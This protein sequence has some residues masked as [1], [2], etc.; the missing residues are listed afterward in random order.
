MPRYHVRVVP[1]NGKPDL[2]L[3]RKYTDFHDGPFTPEF[4]SRV[5]FVKPNGAERRIAAERDRQPN[6]Y[7]GDVTFVVVEEADESVCIHC[8]KPIRNVAY[9]NGLAR[10]EDDQG[11]DICGWGGGDERHEPA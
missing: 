5:T 1:S 8:E 3:S 2:Y 9:T 6:K 11:N 10:W 4:H 7:Y